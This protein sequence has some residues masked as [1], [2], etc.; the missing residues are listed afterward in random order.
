MSAFPGSLVQGATEHMG[1][2]TGSSSQRPISGGARS[3]GTHSQRHQLR[4]SVGSCLLTRHLLTVR[5]FTTKMQSTLA[6]HP[7]AISW[8]S[9]KMLYKILSQSGSFCSSSQLLA[10]SFVHQQCHWL[11]FF[12][13]FFS[14]PGFSSKRKPRNWPSIQGSFPFLLI[15]SLLSL[16][17]VSEK[18][19]M[20]QVSENRSLTAEGQ[21]ERHWQTK[22]QLC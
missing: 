17:S 15:S 9:H 1:D 3:G 8:G 19:S 11:F 16:S 18:K 4:C 6:T 21:K 20:G 5:F 12:S 7:R 13:F 14:S 22:Q 2:W 10:L